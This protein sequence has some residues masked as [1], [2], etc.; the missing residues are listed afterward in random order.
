MFTLAHLSDPHLGPL[1]KV[2]FR[3]LFSKR[4]MGYANW[5]V[6]RRGRHDMATLAN[7][8]L[9]MLSQA[10]DHIA[11]TGD[12][13]VIGLDAEFTPARL[14]LEKLGD[15]QLVSLVPGNHDSYVR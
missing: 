11:C 12:L 7:L 13:A 8:T 15:P 9:D 1:P 3:E 10:P 14:F 2:K 6:R 4:I 5:K